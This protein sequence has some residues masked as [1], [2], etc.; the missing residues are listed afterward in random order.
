MIAFPFLL[1]FWIANLS[2]WI[3]TQ[4]GFF[5]TLILWW[6]KLSCD[7][8]H[9]WKWWKKNISTFQI[10]RNLKN[11]TQLISIHKIWK[12]WDIQILAYPYVTPCSSYL[13]FLLLKVF[14]LNFFFIVSGQSQALKSCKEKVKKHNRAEIIQKKI[15]YVCGSN[16]YHK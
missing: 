13:F 5:S 4:F 1:W 2:Q 7:L 8:F 6:E 15:S 9:E 3:N 16:I 11:I 10:K 14:N 12:E